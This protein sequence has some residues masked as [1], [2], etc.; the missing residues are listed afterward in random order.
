IPHS[1]R[2]DGIRLDSRGQLS[3]PVRL[4]KV[5][6]PDDKIMAAYLAAKA[7]LKQQLIGERNTLHWISKQ[8]QDSR[9]FR[10]LSAK[11][12]ESAGYTQ[13]IL[14]HPMAADGELKMVGDL[15]IREV[16]KPLFQKI[17]ERRLEMAREQGRDGRSSINREIAY[18]S[19]M[20]SWATNYIP[21]LGVDRNPLLGFE[22]IKENRRD[23]YVTDDEY[24]LQYNIAL[25]LP[26][27]ILPI[28]F[29]LSLALAARNLEVIDLRVSDCSEQGIHVHRR[30]GSK[31]TIISWSNNP[32]IP[33]E[34]TRLYQAYK[35]ALAR[36]QQHTILPIDP[37]LL[38]N[39][40][41]DKYTASGI[42]SNMARLKKKMKEQGLEKAFWSLHLLKHKGISDAEDDKIAGHRSES[43]RD[44]YNHKI[45][46]FKPPI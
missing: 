15:H 22:R 27:S 42:Q 10:E 13:K 16:T 18:V 35:A 11:S 38:I 44:R 20:I 8:Y 36:H 25:N 33:K 46:S 40:F 30:K 9:Q 5:G 32:D 21:D 6:D 19:A 7:N 1:E 12:Q 26:D 43:M 4:G 29:E 3:P 34:K 39:K 14:Q 23:R 17:A 45:D 31:D 24:W 37:P 41:G 28:L 2:H